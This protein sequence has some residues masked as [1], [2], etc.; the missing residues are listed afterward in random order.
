M[1]PSPL[2]C[3]LY[4][5]PVYVLGL[6]T[7]SSWVQY[8]LRRISSNDNLPTRP[9]TRSDRPRAIPVLHEHG[10]RTLASR[11]ASYIPGARILSTTSDSE[12]GA[13][14]NYRPPD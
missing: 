2:A 5:L 3:A 7:A 9:G 6:G 10:D 13:C 1:H 11:I 4:L 12:F 14:S 8:L